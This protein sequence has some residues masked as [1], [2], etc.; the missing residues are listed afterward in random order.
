MMYQKGF[1]S[2]LKDLKFSIFYTIWHYVVQ[3]DSHTYHSFPEED[4][5]AELYL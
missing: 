2:L 3:S 5:T 1:I 4:C